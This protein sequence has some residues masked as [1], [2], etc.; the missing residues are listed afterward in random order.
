MKTRLFL[1]AICIFLLPLF[2]APSNQASSQFSAYAC[3]GYNVTSGRCCDCEEEG[4]I[5]GDG[6]A[7]QGDNTPSDL[8]SE[9]LFALAVVLLWLRLR[10]N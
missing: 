10:V 2:F 3:S 9:G 6:L 7:N 8:G 5:C 1:A 4:C